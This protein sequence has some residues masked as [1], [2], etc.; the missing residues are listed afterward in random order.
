MDW[1]TVE[2]PRMDL[3]TINRFSEFIRSRLEISEIN[4]TPLSPTVL[5]VYRKVE[6][7]SY[8]MATNGLTATSE[9]HD[10]RTT[11]IKRQQRQS[12][13]RGWASPY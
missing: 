4:N 6:K 5:R 8:A 3:R 10:L 2:T 12:R 7:A 1:A 13:R 11:A 9:L